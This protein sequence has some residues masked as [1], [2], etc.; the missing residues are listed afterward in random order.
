MPAPVP[1]AHEAARLAPLVDWL[2]A[3]LDQPHSVAA[4]AARAGMS[5]RTFQ[6]RF[7]ETTGLAPGA[8]LLAERRRR[9]CAL[10]EDPDCR[11]LDAVAEACGFGA[12]STLR[13]HFRA[14]FGRSPGA[15]RRS[16]GGQP[17]SGKRGSV[18]AVSNQ[19]TRLSQKI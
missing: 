13:H 12:A 6:R 8:W 14:R 2:R 1:R 7:V 18:S 19:G 16:F 10:L 5:Q 11:S 9:A 17:S 3:T 4:L 15:W